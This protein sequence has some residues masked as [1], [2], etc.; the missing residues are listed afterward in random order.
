MLHSDFFLLNSLFSFV[1]FVVKGFELLGIK[2]I[3]VIL[4]SD[5]FLLTSRLTWLELSRVLTP[6]P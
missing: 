2:K 3:A 4:H 1:P 5:F 6:G